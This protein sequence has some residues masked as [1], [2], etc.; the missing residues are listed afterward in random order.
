MFHDPL[1]LV[2]AVG[3]LEGISYLLLLGVAL[4]SKYGLGLPLGVRILGAVHGLL[5][6]LYGAAVLR[7]AWRLGWPLE[8]TLEVLAMALVPGGTFWLDARLR[9]R[10]TET[11]A[12]PPRSE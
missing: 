8:Q 12:N 9:P 1:R 7:A 3:M 2:R 6:V 5:F 11:P 10:P 4:P